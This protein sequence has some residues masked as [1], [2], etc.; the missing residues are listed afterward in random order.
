M[1][2]TSWDSFKGLVFGNPAVVEEV[3]LYPT[4]L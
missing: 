3:R 2:E 4:L 1:K